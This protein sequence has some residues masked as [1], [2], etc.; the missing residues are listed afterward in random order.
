MVREEQKLKFNGVERSIKATYLK[1][2]LG[3]PGQ[4]KDFEIELGGGYHTV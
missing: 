2:T 4:L 1:G 3:V